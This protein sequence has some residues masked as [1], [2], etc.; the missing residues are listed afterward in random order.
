MANF[1]Q[2]DENNNVLR[3]VSINDKYEFMGEEYC[4]S[5]FGGTWKQ[6][7]YNNTIRKNYAGP[8]FIYNENL[9]AFIPPKPYNSWILNEE[10]CHWKSP[11]EL[12]NDYFVDDYEWIES[13]ENWFSIQKYVHQTY[14]NLYSYESIQECCER[15]NL[16][17]KNIIPIL[18]TENYVVSFEKIEN[19]IISHVTYTQWTQS[20]SEKWQLDYM[21]NVIKKANCDLYAIWHSTNQNEINTFNN[22]MTNETDY[23]YLE[24]KNNWLI[25]KREKYMP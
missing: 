7:S 17:D 15:F 11:L 1:A 2:L 18:S 13:E 24:T 23:S 16:V 9:D 3:V 4:N 6:T 5:L 12:P 21:E 20:V 22:Y 19:F 8:G 10:V 25:Y 14:G